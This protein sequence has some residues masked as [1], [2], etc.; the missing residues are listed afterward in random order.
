MR[1]ARSLCE[2]FLCPT[3]NGFFLL[4]GKQ[5]FCFKNFCHKLNLFRLLLLLLLPKREAIVAIRF[6]NCDNNTEKQFVNL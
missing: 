3:A 5:E 4:H 2:N 6:S 1:C